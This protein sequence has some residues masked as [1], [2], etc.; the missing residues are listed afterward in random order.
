MPRPR[1]TLRVVLA[2]TAIVAVMAWQ[3]GIVLQRK[4]AMESG[5]I[6]I[7]ASEAPGDPVAEKRTVNTFRTWLGDK[8]VRF[9]YVETK[10][11]ATQTINGLQRLFPEAQVVASQ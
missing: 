10:G 5:Q 8:P 2:V 9:I 1:F 7:L 11:D 3:V 4:W 6:F